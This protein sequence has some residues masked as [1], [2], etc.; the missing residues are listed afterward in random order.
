MCE[1]ATGYMF[2]F[3]VYTGKDEGQ[4]ERGLSF[5][6]VAELCSSIL[7][8]CATVF[9]DNFYTGVEILKYLYS[10]GVYACGTIRANRKGL[11]VEILPKRLKLKKH[12]CRLGQFDELTFL[13]WQDTKPVCFLSNFHCP[14]EMGQVNRRGEDRLR[15]PVDVPTIVPD[16]Q[17]NMRGVDLCDQRVGY[18]LPTLKSVKWWRRLFF[19][20]LQ[21]SVHNAYIL[22]KS[23]HQRE[24]TTAYPRF[25]DFLEAVAHGLISNTR[26]GRAAPI[27]GNPQNMGLHRVYKMYDTGKF[28]EN[29]Q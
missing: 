27:V 23:A 15:H 1:S 24:V 2:N 18:Y 12:E 13:A 7:W 14:T 8:T 26:V 3:Q 10:R 29:V 22:A 4:Q 9:F 20:L 11:P 19:Y 17:Q 6:V 25:R 21:V 16:Y 28:V 5:R